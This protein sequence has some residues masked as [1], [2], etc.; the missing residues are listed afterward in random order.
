MRLL[1]SSQTSCI[2]VAE[3]HLLHISGHLDDPLIRAGGIPHTARVSHS[4]SLTTL[5][6]LDLNSAKHCKEK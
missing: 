2:K 1:Q 4:R 3:M 5:I 6:L